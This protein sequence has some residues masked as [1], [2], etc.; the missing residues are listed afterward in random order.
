MAS[1]REREA[2]TTW[3]EGLEHGLEQGA[4][5]EQVVAAVGGQAQFRKG[6]QHGAL[7]RRFLRQ[8]QRLLDVEGG[9]G[10]AAARAGHCNAREVVRVQVEESLIHVQLFIIRKSS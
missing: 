8:A 5:V 3:A 9:V 4:L 1:G 7:V 10:D 6:G 2:S